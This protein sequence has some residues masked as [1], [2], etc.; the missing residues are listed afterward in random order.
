MEQHIK[1]MISNFI[2]NKEARMTKLEQENKRTREQENKRT[3][4]QENK[5]LKDEILRE[6]KHS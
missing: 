4:E 6:R 2:A 1:E 3:R 5:I